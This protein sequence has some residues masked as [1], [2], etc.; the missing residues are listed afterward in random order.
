MQ[1]VFTVILNMAVAGFFMQLALL[2]LH[3]VPVCLVPARVRYVL[4]DLLPL[5]MLAAV[6]D[7][8]LLAGVYLE[9]A[10]QLWA[11]VFAAIFLLQLFTMFRQYFQL[12][13]SRKIES[14]IF[15]ICRHDCKAERTAVKLMRSNAVDVPVTWGLFSKKILLSA[16]INP[17]DTSLMYHLCCHELIHAKRSDHLR[18]AIFRLLQ[19]IFWFNPLMWLCYPLYLR[20][21]EDSCDERALRVSEKIKKEE[22]LRMIDVCQTPAREEKE[23]VQIH[24]L[25]REAHMAPARKKAVQASD[26]QKRIPTGVPAAVVAVVLAAGIGGWF[27]RSPLL[28][29]GSRISYDGKTG[30]NIS[31]MDDFCQ[32]V[33]EGKDDAVELLV[34]AGGEKVKY[35]LVFQKG[36]LQC[37][38]Q[39]QAEKPVT[40]SYSRI[41]KTQQDGMVYYTLISDTQKRELLAAP[42]KSAQDLIEQNLQLFAKKFN[43]ILDSKTGQI[44]VT[45]LQ[46]IY[47]G[48]L[49]N[50][51]RMSSQA[52]YLYNYGAVQQN[53][54]TMLKNNDIESA[55]A[56][57]GDLRL[58]QDFM[59]NTFGSMGTYRRDYDE[60]AAQYLFEDLFSLFLTSMQDQYLQN[61][62]IT[63]QSDQKIGSI[64]FTF[65]DRFEQERAPKLFGEDVPG[66]DNVRPEGTLHTVLEIKFDTRENIQTMTLRRYC[67]ENEKTMHLLTSIYDFSMVGQEVDLYKQVDLESFKQ[68]NILLEQLAELSP[69]SIW[70]QGTV[71]GTDR[72]YFYSDS[73]EKILQFIQALS[74]LGMNIQGDGS[75]TEGTIDLTVSL[76]EITLYLSHD[77]R[78][79]TV[80]SGENR[81]TFSTQIVA[82][83][84]ICNWLVQNLQ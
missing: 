71:E 25:A 32:S 16:N 22:Y 62:N 23:E 70:A 59:E 5:S 73:P 58:V 68:A 67:G 43:A 12:R 10:A 8:P 2:I 29:A 15:D 3:F 60:V 54:V 36:I 75:V 28:L 31:R 6:W 76:G 44:N 39:E 4:W 13:G 37:R 79:I 21:M 69:S 45:N 18:K 57:A 35:S 42:D 38:I 47:S 7:M 63:V 27:L 82:Y 48:S 61:S 40:N 66:I 80:E 1:T 56:S 74:D 26:L 77:Q 9:L 46:T 33:K 50:P 51:I 83:R 53:K 30:R 81:A 78:Q 64:S 41:T 52:A 72:T 24:L 34:T 19:G 84:Y 49:D 14:R 20:D 65:N 11:I 17:E 55:T